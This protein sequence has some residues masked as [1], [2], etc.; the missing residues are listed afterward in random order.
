MNWDVVP[1]QTIAVKFDGNVN[2]ELFRS[3]L[4]LG[5]RFGYT[6]VTEKS[7]D[8]K[9]KK[10]VSYQQFNDFCV[11]Y[12]KRKDKAHYRFGQAFYNEILSG[13][14][15]MTHSDPELFYCTDT[16]K[17]QAIVLARYVEL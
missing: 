13:F 1:Q 7:V 4:E 2:E 16:K 10:Y 5:G 6:V 14:Y 11:A 15:M 3:L 17:A 8:I 9:Y 12:G